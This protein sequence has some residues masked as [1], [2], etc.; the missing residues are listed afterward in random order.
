MAV[1]KEF[2]FTPRGTAEPYCAIQKPDYG[3]PEKGFGNPR[4]VYKVDLTVPSKDAQP[5][6]NKIN[7]L[8]E[9]NYAAICEKFEEDRPSLMAKLGRGKKLQE[10]YEGNMPYFEN[11]DGTVTFKFSSYASY[12]DKNTEELKPLVLKVVDSNGKRIQDVP[13]ISGGSELKARFSMFAYGF[14]AVAGASVKL[15]LDSVM[16]LKLVEFGGGDDDW[17]AEAEEGYVAEENR[18]EAGWTDAE[19][20][21]Q[22]DDD[23]GQYGGDF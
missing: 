13:A 12:V 22:G 1:K 19:Q 2:M 14:S 6:I 5:L 4:G 21:D 16:L 18:Q 23:S 15:Q 7:K 11:D 3:N 10:P 20:A 8:H 9:V 17:A